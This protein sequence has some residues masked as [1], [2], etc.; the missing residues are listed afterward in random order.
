MLYRYVGYSE[1]KRIQRG[2]IESSSAKEAEESLYKAGFQRVLELK[3]TASNENIRRMV[4]GAPTVSK[5]ELLDF[6][7]ELAVLVESGLTLLVALKQ[8]EKQSARKGFQSVVSE[9]VTALL[10]G[11]QLHEAMIVHPSIFP[12]T[13]TSIIAA[14]E[15]S[16]T[17]DTGLRQIAKELKMD[18]ATKAQI[19][20]AVTQPAII[21][22]VAIGVVILMATVVLPNLLSV[23]KEMGAQLP[24]MTRVLI[25]VTDWVNAYKF[26]ILIIVVILVVLGVL[27]FRQKETRRVMD[28]W[29]LRMPL[30]GNI[31]IWNSTARLS[32][33][34]SILLKAG[35]LLPE[36]MNIIL[37]TMSNTT[38]R[39][40]L[41]NARVQ[42]LQG[43]GL[44]SVLGG[45]KV[46]PQLLV[47]M[48]AVGE[49]SGQLESTL[50]TVADYYEV[51][52]ERNINRLTGLLEPAMILGIGLI[53]AVIAI[54]LIS[55]IYG[56]VGSMPTG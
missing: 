52:V 56:L 18:I 1:N 23:F 21:L 12:E 7:N 17:L 37:R 24:F 6:T 31:I 15:Q 46:F 54:S 34:M 32:R 50:E 2:T 11:K 40:A 20:R 41:D 47:E 45:N 13:Y 3:K 30:V 39:E 48:V 55:T 49:T 35:I 25:G 10:A 26:A 43:Q 44:S 9:L 8:L 27:F 29:M 4:F 38:L 28:R 51:K 53:V 22:V 33:T 5:Q 42:L 14:S 19:Q 16:G 36:T